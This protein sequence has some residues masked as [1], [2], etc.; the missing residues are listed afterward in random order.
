[1]ISESTTPAFRRQGAPLLVRLQPS[2]SGSAGPC[3]VSG[4][5]GAF[6]Q[7]AFGQGSRRGRSLRWIS[8]TTRRSHAWRPDQGHGLRSPARLPAS[9]EPIYCCVGAS[10]GTSGIV[11]DS[12]SRTTSSTRT[13]NLCGETPSARA[14][15]STSLSWRLDLC[16]FLG[17]EKFLRASENARTRARTRPPRHEGSGTAPGSLLGFTNSSLQ[18]A[19]WFNPGAPLSAFPVLP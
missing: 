9:C 2:G 1:L 7:G 4:R 3:L 14:H 19:P 17:I 12:R 15:N 6:D 5:S 8:T 16:F 18:P 11:R 10:A 13:K